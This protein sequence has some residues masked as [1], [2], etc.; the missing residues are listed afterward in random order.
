MCPEYTLFTTM[1]SCSTQNSRTETRH[2]FPS[3]ALNVQ[4]NNVAKSLGDGLDCSSPI[5]NVLRLEERR[6]ALV[7][8]FE[9]RL[10]QF[11]VDQA[12]QPLLTI[13]KEGA[14]GEDLE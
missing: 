6:A 10:E 9:S 12:R 3:P 5:G 14:R 7:D 1:Q 8:D 13:P 4:G 2:R 11:G